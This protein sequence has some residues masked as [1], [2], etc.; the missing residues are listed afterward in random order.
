LFEEALW[1]SGIS[2]DDGTKECLPLHSVFLHAGAIFNYKLIDMGK[3]IISAR[4]CQ[5]RLRLK[6]AEKQGWQLY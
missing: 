3:Q 1:L 2:R 4:E 6:D 5:Q